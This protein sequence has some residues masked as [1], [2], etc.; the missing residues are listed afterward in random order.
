[1]GEPDSAKPETYNVV[2]ESGWAPWGWRERLRYKLF[3]SRF[4]PLPEAPAHFKD[5]LEC[6]TCSVLDWLDRLRVLVT[7]K[8]VVKTRTVTE[9][10]IGQS[11]TSSVCYVPLS[12]K[13]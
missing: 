9:H 11:V 3:P 4:V 2:Q 8:I 7:G 6:Q 1:M 12:F 13:E 10:T 5:V